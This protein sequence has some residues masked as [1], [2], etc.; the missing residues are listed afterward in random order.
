MGVEL[1]GESCTYFCSRDDKNSSSK[2]FSN[3]HWRN[4][5]AVSLKVFGTV[6]SY[7][8]SNYP[9]IRFSLIANIAFHPWK[10]IKTST[11]VA[12]L[13]DNDHWWE[14]KENQQSTYRAKNDGLSHMEVAVDFAQPHV[15]IL[16]GCGEQ[17]HLPNV[18]QGQLVSANP[19]FDRIWY[20]RSGKFDNLCIVGRR[21][22]Q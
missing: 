3:V 19:E 8:G 17:V 11:L 13:T 9:S 15:L 21:E 2:R 18:R 22:E 10:I 1:I 12:R 7:R 5:P 20:N 16:R 14:K 4:D 6:A